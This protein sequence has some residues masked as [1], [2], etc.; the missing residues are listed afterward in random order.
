MQAPCCVGKQPRGQHAVKAVAAEVDRE[1]HAVAAWLGCMAGQRPATQL[2]WQM[3]RGAAVLGGNGGG[4]H[5]CGLC[6]G[7]EA[8]EYAEEHGKLSTA[9]TEVWYTEWSCWDVRCPTQGSGG[10]V[11]PGTWSPTRATRLRPP[12]CQMLQGR[13]RG[14]FRMCMRNRRQG[15][16]NAWLSLKSRKRQGHGKAWLSFEVL[17]VSD[18]SKHWQG[19]R[20]GQQPEEPAT[21]SKRDELPCIILQHSRAAQ[22]HAALPNAALQ[23]ASRWTP[24]VQKLTD[25]APV[26]AAPA[27]AISLSAATWSTGCGRLMIND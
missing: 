15:H 8:I 5:A 27:A 17:Q 1:R 2:R 23:N 4:G 12:L 13:I 22:Q 3:V 26:V 20:G 24:Q 10:H 11:A 18:I 19:Q 9:S 7:A 21:S 16:E 6:A 14:V 25:V